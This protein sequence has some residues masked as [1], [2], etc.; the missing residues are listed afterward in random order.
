MYTDYQFYQEFKNKRGFTFC[1]VPQHRGKRFAVTF[2]LGLKPEWRNR[3]SKRWLNKSL[4]E[5][6]PGIVYTMFYSVECLKY[7]Y[8]VAN[9]YNAKL[10]S[11]IAD[12]PF[13]EEI[14][15]DIKNIIQNSND[16]F[17]ISKMSAIHYNKMFD[18]EFKVFHNGPTAKFFENRHKNRSESKN[19]LIRFIG[20]YY[21]FVHED[22]VDDL[23]K[24]IHRLNIKYNLNIYLEFWGGEFPRSSLKK[25]CI[26]SEIS[27]MG[28]FNEKN[29][30]HLH[31]EADLLFLP[32]SFN[33][34]SVDHYRF[35][36]PTKLT[37][38]LA[39]KIP[40]LIYSPKETS[41][42]DYCKTNNLGILV[43]ENK[44]NILEEKLLDIILNYKF[45][46]K[47]AIKNSNFIFE[48]EHANQ[49]KKRFQD[50]L[51]AKNKNDGN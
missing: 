40:T 2:L 30:T 20:N 28:R 49:I 50:T 33:K 46:E 24:V 27:F 16:R 10:I 19:F 34:N 51:L 1:H 29:S 14:D 12:D 23:I 15:K 32:A 44:K 26:R 25:K 38:Y 4:K 48:N 8:W 6:R 39:T 22:A 9:C 47:S 41:F 13:G 35:S 7:A 36:F 43:G 3:Y 21:K 11:H 17:A 5:Y 45:Y 42:Y 37:E 18:C 31:F